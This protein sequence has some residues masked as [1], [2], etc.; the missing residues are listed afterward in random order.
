MKGECRRGE[1]RLT[2]NEAGREAPPNQQTAPAGPGYTRSGR[3]NPRTTWPLAPPADID[4]TAWTA[5]PPGR[6][7]PGR[8]PPAWTPG[9]RKAITRRPT[10]WTAPARRSQARTPPPGHRTPANNTPGPRTTARKGPESRQKR[11]K[12]EPDNKGPKSYAE[13]TWTHC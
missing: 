12:N 5:C 11:E 10:A 7:A 2:G 3:P 1:G 8:L 6:I 4:P 9:P 13:R